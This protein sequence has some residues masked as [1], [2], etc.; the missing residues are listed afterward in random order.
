MARRSVRL[1]EI[2]AELRARFGTDAV[3]AGSDSR[4]ER[5]LVNTAPRT[6][7]DD[8]AKYVPLLKMVLERR[9]RSSQSAEAV[10]DDWLQECRLGRTSV[11][12][13]RA[14]RTKGRVSSRMRQK[15]E[16]AIV[17]SA[18]KLGLLDSE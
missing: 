3:E 17:T 14:G 6:A 7:Q 10:L 9:R 1:S 12:D 15:I 16:R 13:Y 5:P 18:Q 4:N 8:S 2:D 11:T